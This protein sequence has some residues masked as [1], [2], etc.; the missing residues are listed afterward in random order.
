MEARGRYFP[1]SLVRAVT[2]L[3]T[4]IKIYVLKLFN[5]NVVIDVEIVEIN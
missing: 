5:F 4:Y 3:A 1:V 2:G